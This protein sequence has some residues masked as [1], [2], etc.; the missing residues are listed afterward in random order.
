M[1]VVGRFMDEYSLEAHFRRALDALGVTNTPVKTIPCYA[2]RFLCLARAEPLFRA[3][4]E[5]SIIREI[6]ETA[7]GR[8]DVLLIIKAPSLFRS[9]RAV[10]RVLTA[11]KGR[12]VLI[13]PDGLASFADRSALTAWKEGAGLIGTYDLVAERQQFPE[14]R[15]ALF[16]SPFGYDPSL[17]WLQL[18]SHSQSQENVAFVGTWDEARERW[19]RTIS[20]QVPTHVWG[21]YW[22]RARNIG[23]AK[24]ISPRNCYGLEAAMAISTSLAALN[25][26]RPQNLTRG[27]MR[28]YELAASGGVGLTLGTSDAPTFY[29]PPLSVLEPCGV[30][31]AI[32]YLQALGTRGRRALAAQA[33]ADVAPYTYSARVADV[34]RAALS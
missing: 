5:A 25:I 16:S 32:E 1:V 6:H 17:H 15:S 21:G 30:P 26:P 23:H 8:E 13:A 31:D 29:P 7:H 14:L 10:E 33:Q 11:W 18:G 12:A 9:Q 20:Y 24:L 27:N 28:T 19:V 22:N 34:L 4:S 2:N 3:N